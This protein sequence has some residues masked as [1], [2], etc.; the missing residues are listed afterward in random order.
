MKYLGIVFSLLIILGC[1]RI[2]PNFD[3]SEVAV[4]EEKSCG[5]IQNSLGQR[6]SWNEK[7]PVIF[8]FS[9]SVPEDYRISITKAAEEWNSATG[10]KIIQM[11]SEVIAADEWKSDGKNIIYWVDRPDVFTNPFI[12]AKSLIRWS[13]NMI[14]DVDILVNAYDWS[15]RSDA[16]L[17]EGILD[18]ESLLVHEFGH[19]LGLV[20]QNINK[21]VMFSNLAMETKR[22]TPF[23]KPDVEAI[24]CEYQ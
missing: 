17:A 13:G 5:F 6:V 14:T 11:Q 22:V 20:H 15:F 10:K 8:Y 1:N 12:Q 16:S 21:S 19:A 9:S 24:K 3:D 2:H 23:E 4:A 7:M 18:L